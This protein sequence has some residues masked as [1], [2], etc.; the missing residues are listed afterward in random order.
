MTK[1]GALIVSLI[2]ACAV[3]ALN[4]TEPGERCYPPESDPDLY[5]RSGAMSCAGAQR[6]VLRIEALVGEGRRLLTW[7]GAGFDLRVLSEASGLHAE[8]ARLALGSVDMMFHLLAVKGYPLSLAAALGGMGLPPKTGDGAHAVELWRERRFADV[9][10]YC[11]EDARRT[12]SLGLVTE[13][14]DGLSWLSKRGN[15]QHLPL[16]TGWLTV[17]ECLELPEPDT[18]WMNSPLRRED[19]LAWC[20]AAR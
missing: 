2:I 7:N 20:L 8:C 14:M 17:A 12:L 6:L 16:P 9:L 1:V 18:S 4:E 19:V 11:D 10:D 3:L 15:A 13:E 5:E